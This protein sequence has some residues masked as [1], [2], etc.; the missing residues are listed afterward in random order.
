[1]AKKKVEKKKP[2]SRKA[3]SKAK[4]EPKP[5]R[6]IVKSSSI[7]A[8]G[9]PVHCAH[10]KIVLTRNLVPHPR[11]PNTHPDD[12]L[13]LLAKI[14]L[15]GGWRNPI[16][17]S[18]LSGC[19]V[20]GHG[21]LAAA[22]MLKAK[23]VPVDYQDY[24]S[25]EE[26]LADL[27]ADNR[28][29]ELSSFDFSTLRTELGELD[30]GAFDMELTGF[31]EASMEDVMTWTQEPGSGGGGEGGSGGGGGGGGDTHFRI[32]VECSSQTNQKKLLKQFAEEG[33]TARAAN[34]GG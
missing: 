18:N 6:R 13:A 11:N 26:E 5:K 8:D 12:Q 34:R 29:A 22:V 23:K 14:I 9:I 7:D 25:A 30:T 31:D 4:A 33:L 15:K 10:D 27:I 1:M 3:P 32:L 21:R 17:V 2:A 28:I 24:D 19:I 16:T 20:R